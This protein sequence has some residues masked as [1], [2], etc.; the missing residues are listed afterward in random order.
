[1]TTLTALSGSALGGGFII[2]KMQLWAGRIMSTLTSLFL[3]V[4]GVMKLLKP[5]VVLQATLQLGYAESAIIGI[6][7]TLLV[8]ALL[9]IVPR[10]STVGAVLLTGYL[11]GAVASNVRAGMPL[12]NVIFP[13]IIA[14]L[15]W[16]GLWFRDLRV[17][18][19]LTNHA[20]SGK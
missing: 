13:M 16:G 12:F 18:N 1:M 3:V 15:A 10:T 20:P 9:Y 11:G 5:P 2:S 19:L 14:G 6:G 4:D 8:C 17:R 7:A